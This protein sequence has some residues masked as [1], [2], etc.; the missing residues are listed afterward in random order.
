ML[1]SFPKIF[2]RVSHRFV[3]LS[4]RST[5]FPTPSFQTA[6]RT[7][8]IRMRQNKFG[9]RC[10][11]GYIRESLSPCSVPVLLV[12]KKDG[13]CRMCVDCR[14]INNITIRY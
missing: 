6:P 7:V 11:K 13:S 5:S 4:T 9:A 1:M 12:P 14:D 10:S 3:A 8:H 2:H